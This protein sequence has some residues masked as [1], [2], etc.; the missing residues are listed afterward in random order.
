[1]QKYQLNPGQVAA[2]QVLVA[3]TNALIQAQVRAPSSAPAAISADILTTLNIVL[4]DVI[5]AASIYAPAVGVPTTDIPQQNKHF[6]LASVETP[7]VVGGSVSLLLV[8]SLNAFA[9]IAI[10]PPAAAAITVLATAGA[11]LIDNL[12]T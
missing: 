4:D 7:E 5:S 10:S 3:T 6:V 11:A 9:H 1:M 8:L 2:V 12:A